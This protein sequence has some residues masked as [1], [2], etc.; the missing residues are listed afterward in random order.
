MNILCRTWRAQDASQLAALCNSVDRRYLA[1]RL[2]YPYTQ[3][4][5][6]S[7]LQMVAAHDEKDGIFRAIVVDGEIVGNISVEQK[8]DVYRCDGELGYLL[9]DTYRGQGIMSEAVRQICELT[10][11][12]LSLLRITAL[13]Y[14]P[15]IASRRVLEKNSF[16]LEGIL[17]Q[18]VIK[19]NVVYGICVYGKLAPCGKHKAKE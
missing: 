1:D 13:V 6:E 12:R 11:Q 8:Q 19:E 9:A 3:E 17:Q 15:H 7:W 2:P 5:A 16:R 18:A 10:F 14:E 4:H